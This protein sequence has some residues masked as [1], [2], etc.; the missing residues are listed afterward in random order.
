MCGEPEPCICFR[1]GSKPEGTQ[2]SGWVGFMF[3]WF[4]WGFQLC[5]V[6]GRMLWPQL[7]YWVCQSYRDP[8]VSNLLGVKLPL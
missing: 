1:Q 2:A 8:G 6:I 4:L 5:R 7:L 3:L